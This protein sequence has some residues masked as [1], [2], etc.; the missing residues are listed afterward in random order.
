VTQTATKLQITEESQPGPDGVL[1]PVAPIQVRRR[2]PIRSLRQVWGER[3][4]IVRTAF[5]GMLAG[6]LLAFLL[7]KRF[8]STT[9]LMPP[10]NQSGSG[11][12]MSAALFAKTGS[13]LGA[14]AGGLSGLNSSGALFVG[15]LRSR[16]VEDRLVER[17]NL[18]SVYG[19]KIEEDAR[20]ALADK[21]AIWEDRQ[22]RIIT[23]TVADR[24]PRRAAAIAQAYVE[25]LDRLVA[26]LS[27]SSARREREFLEDRLKAVQADLEA[28]EKEFSQFASKNTA[29]DIKEQGKARVDAAAALEGQL[30]AAKAELEGLKQIYT[31]NNVRVRATRARIA[32]FQNQLEKIGGKGESTSSSGSSD[33]GDSLYPS[34]R[35]LP[36]LG[37]TYADLYRRTKVEEVVYE[38]LTQQYELAKVQEVRET[39]SVKVLDPATVPERRSFPPRRRIVFL[40]TFLALA[41]AVVF[42]FGRTLWQEADAQDPSKVFAQEVFQSVN[43]NMPWAPPNGSRWQAKTHKV[44]VKV[45]RRGDALTEAER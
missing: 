7:P 5:V 1:P 9:Q 36:L 29:I 28:A 31:D 38:T 16:T 41:S 12:A 24:D 33:S 34:I 42:V 2:D 43:A 32:E 27:T 6:T 4:L 20:R 44:W 11:M 22:S 13:D 26:Q 37:V 21:T 15:I 45:F 25:E 17:L 23:I 30:I 10:D 35:K 40:C 39:P 18:K 14:L 3:R 19:A 8:E